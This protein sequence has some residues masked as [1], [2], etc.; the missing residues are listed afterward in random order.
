M[1]RQRKWLEVPSILIKDMPMS[2]IGPVPYFPNLHRQL[3][4]LAATLFVSYLEIHHPA[5]QDDQG[6]ILDLPVMVSADQIAHDLQTGRRTLLVTLSMLGVFWKSEEA[7]AR[8]ARGNREFLPQPES[9]YPGVKIYSITGSHSWRPNVQ[10]AIRRNLPL[11]HHSLQLAGIQPDGPIHEGFNT[12]LDE[13]GLP[14]FGA[15]R[16]LGGLII[17]RSLLGRDGRETK[18]ERMAGLLGKNSKVCE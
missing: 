1:S 7:R 6:R 10:W 3:R 17:S 5:P 13:G 12:P 2:T 14:T 15:F 4:S 9:T 16:S 11:L 18:A 8:G